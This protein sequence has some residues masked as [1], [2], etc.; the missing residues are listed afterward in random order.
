MLGCSS[1]TIN[2]ESDSMSLVFQKSSLEDAPRV[3]FWL[4]LEAG[5]LPQRDS[6]DPGGMLWEGWNFNGFW[7]GSRLRQHGQAVVK[8]WFVGPDPTT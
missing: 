1:N 7:R 6:G 5:G 3:D 2:T 4:I 8:G